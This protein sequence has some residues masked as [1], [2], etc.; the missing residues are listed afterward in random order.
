MAVVSDL[1]KFDGS[2]IRQILGERKRIERTLEEKDGG[3][4]REGGGEGGKE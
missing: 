1:R 2:R 4:R 3:G